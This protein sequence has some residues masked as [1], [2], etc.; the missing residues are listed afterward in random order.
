MACAHVTVRIS[1]SK[2]GFFAVVV[3]HADVPMEQYVFP[4]STDP[5]PMFAVTPDHAGGEIKLGSKAAQESLFV[6]NFAAELVTVTGAETTVAGVM[7]FDD[8]PTG[9]RIPAGAGACRRSL[10]CRGRR[11]SGS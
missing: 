10:V 1:G 4:S 9:G 3:T 6:K 2:I 8:G 11:A 5:A 7:R